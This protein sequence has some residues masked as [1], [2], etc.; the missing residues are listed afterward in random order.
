MHIATQNGFP[1]MDKNGTMAENV[2]ENSHLAQKGKN[3]LYKPPAH[4]FEFRNHLLASCGK[5]WPLQTPKSWFPSSHSPSN[6]ENE[7]WAWRNEDT[8]RNREG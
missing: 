5:K 8:V 3:N 4:G 2:K 1:S 6:T 7:L